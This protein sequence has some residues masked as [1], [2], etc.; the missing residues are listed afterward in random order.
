MML[1]ISSVRFLM[2]A[3]I[4]TSFVVF[5]SACGS[6]NT[7]TTTTTTPPP[8]TQA[9]IP[10]VAPED[11]AAR[12]AGGASTVWQQFQTAL[13]N[14]DSVV[15]CNFMIGTRSVSEQKRFLPD[16]QKS[17]SAAK[18]SPQIKNLQKEEA[19]FDFV[20][21]GDVATPDSKQVT[22]AGVASFTMTYKNGTW[23]LTPPTGSPAASN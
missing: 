7:P 3:L 19:K 11:R 21:K 13:S 8:I 17:L 15:A 16:C 14:G 1:N 23:W 9:E 12:D 2:A 4:I 20:V 18:D 22:S 10:S 5:L 6:K